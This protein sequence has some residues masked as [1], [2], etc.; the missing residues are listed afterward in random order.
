MKKTL[1]Y[2]II[3]SMFIAFIACDPIEDRDITGNIVPA[4]EF[5]YTISQDPQNDYIIYLDNETP[6]VMFS[7]DYAWGT[8]NKQKDTVQMLV[9]GTYNI[10]ITGTTAGGLVT[11]EQ[12]ITVTKSDPDAFQ[13]PEWQMLT[14]LA[15]GKTWVWDTN[16]AAMWGNGSFLSD[17][18]A[19]WWTLGAAG[20]DDPDRDVLND[21]MTFDLNGGRHLTLVAAKTPEPGT[22]QGVFDLDLT[23]TIDDWS[24]GK[25]T[26]QNVTI[27]YGID[28]N[29]GNTKYYDYYILKLTEDELQLAATQPGSGAGSEAWFWMFKSKK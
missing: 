2:T 23:S 16:Q 24:I 29:Q 9:P 8:S 21:E 1:L 6:E 27:I 14:N 3:G 28:V 4:S 12:A 17:T 5:K 13:E 15:E 19:T 18:H 25:L 7:W 10:K 20:L 22:I 11:T 26:T